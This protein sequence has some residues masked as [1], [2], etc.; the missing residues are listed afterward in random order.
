MLSFVSITSF[1]YH[2]FFGYINSGYVDNSVTC[3]TYRAA[4]PVSMAFEFN[5]SNETFRHPLAKVNKENA[6]LLG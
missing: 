5:T 6:E 3:S 2:S 4:T 1:N